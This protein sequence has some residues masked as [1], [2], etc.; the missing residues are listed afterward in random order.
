MQLLLEWYKSE[1]PPSHRSCFLYLGRE[2]TLDGTTPWAYKVG[3]TE[4]LIEARFKELKT[5]NPR[6][7]SIV[8]WWEFSTA[9][10]MN[11]AERICHRLLA[12]YRI[13]GG[14]IEWFRLEKWADEIELFWCSQSDAAWIWMVKLV[15]AVSP[16]FINYVFDETPRTLAD[17]WGADSEEY[18]RVYTVPPK[19]SI[20]LSCTHSST[21]RR[22]EPFCVVA[23]NGDYWSRSHPAGGWYPD[24][25]IRGVPPGK[26]E[27]CSCAP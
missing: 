4:R 21:T 20:A 18:Q 24:G 23:P 9:E 2:E 11:A 8:A 16:R 13:I 15:E 22:Y 25:G 1:E 10:E 27:K 19:G 14:G 7:L 17:A 3:C 6:R 5:G 12:N 26:K